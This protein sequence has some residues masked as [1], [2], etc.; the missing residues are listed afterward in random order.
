MG[1]GGSAVLNRRVSAHWGDVLWNAYR[2]GGSWEYSYPR[3]REQ[4]EQEPCGVSVLSVIWEEQGGR[5]LEQSWLRR[6]RDENKEVVGREGGQVAGLHKNFKD[7]WIWLGE[8]GSNWRDMSM[9][10][11]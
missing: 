1:A 10:G 6:S 11:L 8:L 2:D 5:W 4:K 9:E 3:P 7:F